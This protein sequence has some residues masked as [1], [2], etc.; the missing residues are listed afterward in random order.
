MFS[1]TRTH[2]SF[3]VSLLFPP[4]KPL[5]TR[6]AAPDNLHR[7]PTSF[8]PENPFVLREPLS[9]PPNTSWLGSLV[10]PDWVFFAFDLSKRKQTK[11]PRALLFEG[12]VV[13][14]GGGKR[15]RL[16]FCGRGG[17]F[18]RG[19]GGFPRFP[20]FGGL[21]PFCCMFLLLLFSFNSFN[22]PRTGDTC[23]FPK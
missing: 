19:G 7:F 22:C 14:L 8:L 6:E 9:F 20:P 10:S 23:P 5:L 16:V 12:P 3:L 15:G 11:P 13:F 21:P 2:P 4:P 17:G 1:Q 18:F